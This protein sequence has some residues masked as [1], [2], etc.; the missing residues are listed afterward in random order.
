MVSR[1]KS[2]SRT[3]AQGGDAF[4]IRDFYKGIKRVS[5]IDRIY[6]GVDVSGEDV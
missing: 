3:R 2:R 4:G 5:G 6:F 1:R